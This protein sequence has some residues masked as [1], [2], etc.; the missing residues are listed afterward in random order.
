M[1][2]KKTKK[3]ISPAPFIHSETKK[4]VIAVFFF[5]AALICVLA[6]FGFGG[7]IGNSFFYVLSKTFGWGVFLLIIALA[8]IGFMFIK[9]LS[10]AVY[11]TTIISI[12]V[13]FLSILSIVQLVFGKASGGAVGKFLGANLESMFDFS[14]G[15][16]VSFALFLASLLITL[17]TSLIALWNRI[18]RKNNEEKIEEQA[19]KIGADSKLKPA[20]A[21]EKSEIQKKESAWSSLFKKTKIRNNIENKEP[22]RKETGK[23]E[24]SIKTNFNSKK[25]EN[26]DGFSLDLLIDGRDAAMQHLYNNDNKKTLDSNSYIIKKTLENF[27]IQ[28]EVQNISVGPAVTQYAIK[29]AEGVKLSKI[30]ALQNDLALA[31]AAHPI[32]IE[33]PIPGKSLVGVEVPNKSTAMVRLKEILTSDPFKN[34]KSPL[35]FALGLDV[36]GTPIVADLAKMPHM[37]IAGS[38]GSGKS[39]CINSVITSLLYSNSPKK[40]RLILVDP[41]RVELTSYNGIPHLLCPVIVDPGKTVNA[42]KWGIREMEER[43]KKLQEAGA[44]E[45]ESYNSKKK[46][47]PMPYIVIIIDEL[48]DLM[49]NNANEIE[50]GIVRLAQMARAVGIHLIVS[51]QRPSVE[52]I[53]GLIKANIPARIAFRVASQ[54]DSRTILDASGAEKLLGNGDMLFSAGNLSKPKRIQNAFLAEEEVGRITEYLISLNKTENGAEADENPDNIV[55]SI[56]RRDTINRVSAAR[57][58]LDSFSSDADMEDELYNDAKEIV[59]QAG[60]ASASLFQR[61]L[62]IGYSRAARLLDL[63]EE[64]KVIG[65]ADGA[66]PRNVFYSDRNAHDHRGAINRTMEGENNEIEQ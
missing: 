54:I 17:N 28:T 7:K 60:K 22:A 9:S 24:I 10:A 35:T 40:L 15:L 19:E 4:A 30:V 65:P 1:S 26:Y 5:A 51:T 49:A 61:K 57:F 63:L 18:L 27:G 55:E 45:I 32:R 8:A 16:V 59:L 41:K 36:S 58:D 6:A 31:L 46:D 25:E 62:R 29:P 43:L 39:V 56:N 48:A 64:Q 2:R 3:S 14:G 13:M 53:T 66:R 33:A 21:I 11:S 44:R 42:L 52:V 12:T 37:L 23:P 34:R 50:A 47:E 20:G 38:T